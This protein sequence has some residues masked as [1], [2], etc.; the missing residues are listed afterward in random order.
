MRAAG[1]AGTAEGDTVKRLAVAVQIQ[2][3]RRTRVAQTDGR[4]G[5]A[6]ADSDRK[7][8]AIDGHR[9]RIGVTTHQRQCARIDD[10]GAS[11]RCH[12]GNRDRSGP[13]LGKRETG[14]IQAAA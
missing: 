6:V 5:Q 14:P 8:A 11:I 7:R 2:G 1:R 10:G 13:G 4:N 3:R 9:T 12:G